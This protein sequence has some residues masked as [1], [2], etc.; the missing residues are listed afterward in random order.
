MLASNVIDIVRRVVND[1]DSE[2][3]RWSDSA[4]L[5]YI[6]DAERRIYELRPDLF[7]GSGDT[8]GSPGDP[9]ATGSTLNLDESSREPI[10]AF[11][12]AKALAE[13]GDDR[14]NAE[15]SKAYMAEFYRVVT[16]K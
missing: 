4:L 9:S 16:G 12:V 6:G 5:K 11:V 14:M 13:D 3:E 15:L 8:M 10:V 2:N 1:E 7:L